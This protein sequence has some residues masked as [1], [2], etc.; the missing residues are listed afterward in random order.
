[1]SIC[2]IGKNLTAL[3]LAKILVNKGKNV[4]LFFKQKKKIKNSYRFIGLSNNSIEFFEKQKIFSK[5]ICWPIK[6][7]NLYKGKNPKKFF[8]FSDNNNYFFMASNKK[9]YST[10]ERKIKK[11]KLFKLIKKN[12]DYSLKLLKKNYEI[13]INTE[14]NNNLS[15]KYFHKY[16][17][18]DYKSF[19]YTAVITHSKI[20]NNT[21]EQYFT[22]YGPLAFLPISDTRTSIVFSIFNKKINESEHKVKNCIKN[23]SK[24]YD[25]KDF[26]TFE[27][28]RINMSLSRN[29]YY[30]NILL[31]G[32]A[33]HKIHPL[34]GQGFNMTIRDASILSNLIKE[35]QELG[36][37]LHNILQDFE[38]KRKSNNLLFA[39]GIDFIHEFFK[40]S[41]KYNI[42]QIDRFLGFIDK[43]AF[44]KSKLQKFANIG[45]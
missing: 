31:F 42:Q 22:V 12:N 30:G 10:L 23:Y 25:I 18:K 32:D 4:D 19:A 13:I 3:M 41:N 34:A 26:S 38:T 6:K 5:R 35:K 21:A 16:I 44:I 2:V 39:L 43:N 33:L 29:Y 1:M 8:S 11:N 17:K 28:F 37:S 40:L 24:R 9:L 14:T 27:K 45:F 20:I 15:K 7:I 36:L